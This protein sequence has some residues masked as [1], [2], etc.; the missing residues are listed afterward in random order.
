MRPRCHGQAP[1]R[2]Q[3]LDARWRDAKNGG[4]IRHSQ[5]LVQ[6]TP[7]CRMYEAD[8]LK[9]GAR[10]RAR[11]AALDTPPSGAWGKEELSVESH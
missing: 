5:K 11:I 3:P 9:V 6:V 1:S 2:D 4:R 7:R 10:G 8:S